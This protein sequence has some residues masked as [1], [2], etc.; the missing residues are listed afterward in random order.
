[1]SLKI[2]V[3]VKRVVDPYVKIHVRADETD[4]ETAHAKHAMNPFDE[5]AVE[6]A[7][8]WKEQAQAAE[9]VAVSAGTDVVQETLRTAL[10]LGADRAVHIQA[11]DK[12]EPLS[13]AKLL[14]A[15][16]K[17]EQADIVILG[18]QAIDDDCN[19]VGQMLSA[20]LDWPQGTF[21]SQIMLED[22]QVQV[23]REID[24]GLQTLSLKLPC[25]LTT[26]L[27]LNEPRYVALPNIMKAKRKPLDIQTAE[28]LG[29]T[30]ES[31]LQTLKVCAPPVRKAG[32]KVESVEQ[33]L[34]HLRNKDKVI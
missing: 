2:L 3:P 24:G 18:K 13:V 15:V 19:Q 31:R 17:N 16:T 5:I 29:V 21:A 32:I 23:T 20:L 25:V 12:L 26:D 11:P 34:D 28:A 27:R 1:M 6:Q 4:V 8:R 22:G 10:A 30:V 7:I 14:A 9:V 33:L